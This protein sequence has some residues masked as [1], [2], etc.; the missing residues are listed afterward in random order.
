MKNHLRALAVSSLLATTLGTSLAQNDA[1]AAASLL[2]A[3]PIASVVAETGASAKDASALPAA[4]SLAGATLSVVAVE[5]SATGVVYVLER[6][7]DGAR[8]SVRIASKAAG[9]AS[10][11]VGTA[12]TV[13]TFAAGVV[14][15]AAGQVLAFVPNAVGRALLHNEKVTR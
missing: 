5:T 4:F 13:S 6:A 12:V 7:S 11:A 8:A 10:V 15:S 2:S 14:L 9:H 3:L 1:S